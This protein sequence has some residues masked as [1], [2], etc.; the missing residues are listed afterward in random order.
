M[1]NIRFT[2]S[3]IFI[4]FLILLIIGIVFRYF[5]P[6]QFSLF[7]FP[8][9]ILY[10]TYITVILIIISFLIFLKANKLYS[11]TNNL[12]MAIIGGGF[13]A[14]TILQTQELLFLLGVSVAGFSFN[15]SQVLFYLIGKVWA[16]SVF[17]TIF[18]SK[19]QDSNPK[20]FRRN[21]YL[22]FIIYALIII[23]MDKLLSIYALG[24]TYK[25]LPNI[26]LAK[27]T[28]QAFYLLAAF[29]YTDI[30][31]AA[32]LN[33]IGKFTAGL[34]VLG[35]APLFFIPEFSSTVY[36]F[37]A[38]T[39]RIIGFILLYSGLDNLLTFP[40]YLNFRQKL[41][42]YLSLFIILSYIIFIPVSSIIL[43]LI[44]PPI[45]NMIFIG[46]FVIAAI[47]QYTLAFKFTQPLTNIIHG[48]EKIKPD[49]KPQNI[50]VT[51][52]D[53]IGI[54]ADKLNQS[55]YKLWDYGN[56]ERLIREIIQASRSSLEIDQVLKTVCDGVAKLFHAGRATIV[57]FPDP[58]NYEQIIVRQE[59]KSRSDIK[60]A[61]W[62][63]E[64]L[65]V[66]KFWGQRLLDKGEVFVIDNLDKAPCPDYFKQFYLDLEV[67]SLI[68]APIKSGK[69]GWG[70]I[71]LSEVDYYRHWTQ[72]EIKLLETT[73]DQINIAIKQAELFSITKRQAQNAQLVR[74]IL[75]SIGTT[76]ELEKVLNIICYEVL[77]LFNVDRVGI[78]RYPDPNNYSDWS[79][80]S[81]YKVNPN[82]IGINDIDYPNNT[83]VYFGQVLL[84]ND[85]DLIAD[86]IQESDLPDY[87][88]K[89][90]AQMQVK[91]IVA[92]PVKKR[93]ERWGILV[94]SQVYT[95]RHWST[96]ELELLHTIADQIFIAISQAELYTSTKKNAERESLLRHITELIRSSLNI[97]E[98]LTIICDEMAELFQVQRAAISE[99]VNP[100][101]RSEFIVRREYKENINIKG[102]KDISYAK[103][104]GRYIGET[105]VDKGINLIIDNISKAAV[106]DIF[107]KTYETMGVKSI[108]C[109]PIKQKDDKWGTIFLSEYNYYRHWT[110][111]EVSLLETIA[112]QIYIAIKQAELYS[113][114]KSKAERE[115]LIRDM[116]TTIRSTLDLNVIKHTFVNE[117]GKLF[118]ADR[119]FLA[120]FDY[121]NKV[122]LPVDKYSEYRS[123]TEIK[124]IV[125]DN[126]E[127]YKD[128]TDILREN[129]EIIIPDTDDFINQNPKATTAKEYL[130]KYSIKSGMGFPIL[131]GNQVL[132]IFAVQYVRLKRTFTKDE[133]S[134]LGTLAGQVGLTFYQAKL[135][136]TVKE[137]AE[138]ERLLKEIISE[139]K[140]SESINQIYQ[141]L[142]TKLVEIFKVE[143]AVFVEIPLY[144]HQKPEIKFEYKS[145]N[146]ISSIIG[147]ELPEAYRESI[148]NTAASSQ[149]VM[150]YYANK[151]Y[152]QKEEIEIQRFFNSIGISSVLSVPLVKYNHKLEILG[153]ILICSQKP[154]EWFNSEINLLQEIASSVINI[155]WEIIRRSQIE[156]LRNTFTLTLAHDLQVPL[157]GEKTALEFLATRPN[158]QP[159]GKSKEIIKEILNNNQ[160]LFHL[161]QKLLDTYAYESSKKEL[162]FKQNNIDS[163]ISNVVRNVQDKA[164]EKNISISIDVQ[165]NI[166]DIKMDKDEI[167][168]VLRT[169]C[170]NAVTYIQSGGHIDIT[171]KIQGNTILTCVADNGPGI[172]PEI[173]ERIFERYAMAVAIERKIGAGLGLYLAKQIIEAHGGK[174]WFDTET[175]I[176]T[177]FCFQ[178]PI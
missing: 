36:A 154:R 170:E 100:N 82:I 49:E 165:S 167:S 140:I 24:F 124:E 10:R 29:I 138:Q 35:I 173:R 16:V 69:E 131:H 6:H 55:A 128:F 143:R 141:Y 47:I 147:F 41:S 146:N 17:L 48:I 43:G 21:I 159:I 158:E 96:D 113:S 105:V 163:V 130:R 75:E 111:E 109:V 153:A 71:V 171:S 174:I 90:Y 91:S 156:E 57:Q 79:V 45:S 83:K 110:D 102:L 46:F 52:H 68:G 149:P 38:P 164:A 118:N 18:Y 23:V 44:F 108:L 119:V 92:V 121:D 88:K 162:N 116:V 42:A 98:I 34:Y 168:R 50:Q 169:L 150:T 37:I 107:K 66:A 11:Q 32:G 87:F 25:I 106:P 80:S 101:D 161:L 26:S 28:E 89:T 5:L 59:Y 160:D 12:K 31:I 67:K 58:N 76:L 127:K 85:L 157:V 120:E 73:A 112:I 40:P 97:D 139:I 4:C 74:K 51:T 103:E 135:Y 7:Y 13:L 104:A 99:F 61:V 39:I 1:N 84:D 78:V 3:I 122:F 142:I 94:L 70:M 54:L 64:N 27:I 136:N 95:F 15:S 172:A 133:L 63:S 177:T 125:G 175:G 176:G 148:Q 2:S 30:R 19:F 115:T 134:F 20:D 132:G 8:L 65:P 151:T 114:I 81:E 166:P 152:S 137:N 123:S 77:N 60:S 9:G 178:L 14:G 33:P 56:R 72:D 145:N 53:E 155:V 117:V 126:L 22:G 93:N 144:K 86:N 129:Q 62:V